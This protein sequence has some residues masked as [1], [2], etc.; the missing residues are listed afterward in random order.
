MTAENILTLCD[1]G[2]LESLL[3]RVLSLEEYRER[4]EALKHVY[5]V[6]RNHLQKRVARLEE[7][8]ARAV[9]RGKVKADAGALAAE[10]DL[11]SQSDLS[12]ALPF[13]DLASVEKQHIQ[14]VLNYT[15]GNKVEAAKLLNVGL[16]TVYRKMEEYG[17]NYK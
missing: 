5:A 15:K 6:E 9:S 1:E 16:T 17:L 7:Q 11:L 3:K 2:R 10:T 12:A 14:R 8:A 4:E 13:P